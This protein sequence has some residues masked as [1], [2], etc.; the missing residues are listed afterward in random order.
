MQSDQFNKLR[1][2]NVARDLIWDSQGKIIPLFR[3]TEFGEESGEFAEAALVVALSRIA[4][5]G[6]NTGKILGVVKKLERERMGLKG[7]RKTTEDL[8]HE[9]GDALI[10]L[11]LLCMTYGI[12]LWEAAKYAFNKKSDEH[13]F[14]V[15]L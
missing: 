2:A 8:M 10:T 1:S 5:L 13:G 11:D 14:D 3:A 6:T 9:A 15:H 4:E 7:S 12:D